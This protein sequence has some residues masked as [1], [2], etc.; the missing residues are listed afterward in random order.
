M[1]EVR[2]LETGTLCFLT[3][4]GTLCIDFTYGNPEKP[5]SEEYLVVVVRWSEAIRPTAV[6]MI[7]FLSYRTYSVGVNTNNSLLNWVD[8]FGNFNTRLAI[9]NY[10]N[11]ARNAMPT[12]IEQF[13]AQLDV[14]KLTEAVDIVTAMPESDV[15]NKWSL[16]LHDDIKRFRCVRPEEEVVH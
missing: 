3:S 1:I 13:G 10:L 7:S 2:V 14:E 6:E 4:A 16:D 9:H 11:A 15:V 12:I 5:S 8:H